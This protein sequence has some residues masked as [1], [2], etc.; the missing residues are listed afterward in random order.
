MQ[1]NVAAGVSPGASSEAQSCSTQELLREI[2]A[3][4]GSKNFE[5]WFRGKVSLKL[6]TDE[7][8][9]G[10]G[11]TFLL[12]W[13][14]KHFL[15]Q[16][17]AAAQKVMG[18]SARVRFEVD[19]HA[20]RSNGRKNGAQSA[21]SADHNDAPAADAGP[22]SLSIAGGAR[23]ADPSPA[24]R[25]AQ[26]APL[27]VPLANATQVHR[28]GS[29]RFADLADFVPGPNNEL[30]LLAARQVCDAPGARFNPLFLYGNAGMGKTHLLEGIYRMIRRKHPTHQV[31]YLTSE[32]FANH[33][34]QA[35][36]EHA[37][38]GFRHRFRGVDMLLIDD[39]DFFDGKR[40]IQEEFLHTF[41]QLQ[42]HGRQ[43]VVAADRHP[44]L[45]TKVCEDLTTR[46][47]SGLVCR[48]EPPD[49]ETRRKIVEHKAA[50]L[51]EAVAPEAL[52]LIAQKFRNNVRELE[53]ALNCLES[54]FGLTRRKISLTAARQV[55]AGMDRD[56][57]RIVRIPDVEQAVCRF[58][59]VAAGDLRGSRR[60]RGLSQPRMLA[61]F[62]IRKHTHAAYS[63]IGRHFGGR[64]HSTVIAAEKRVQ[65]LLAADAPIRVS[66]T[67]W[68]MEE[69][70]N[71]IEQQLQVG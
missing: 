40:V 23:K 11:S 47:V 25:P 61:M 42:S 19:P 34:T 24:E 30:A 20:S 54:Y 71:C 9:L 32:D 45:L 53:G 5:H 58:F 43:V 33:F 36:R 21:P 57:V 28:N 70:L 16:V 51:R 48:I 44:R 31:L 4:V 52:T 26:A 8:V 66:S 62:L 7:L 29:R 64:N 17:A 22:P 18:S 13:M 1:P 46:F 49:F 55:L 15:A 59:G 35:L 68:R 65:A 10:I 69:L 60:S 41:Q 50:R 27:S 3:F 39:V 14:Q 56:C 67:T 63:E 37:L 38:P 2:E 6:H 12:T